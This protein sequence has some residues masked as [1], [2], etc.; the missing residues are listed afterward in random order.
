MQP[1]QINAGL[2]FL[3]GL[4]S[5]VSPCVLPLVPAY[6]S[7]LTGSTVEDLRENAAPDARRAAVAHAL[8]FILGFT[9]VFV[10][11]GATAT[12]AGAALRENQVLIA[13]IGGVIV[14]VLGLQMVGILR[15]RFLAM[16]TRVQVQ[17]KRRSFWASGLVG[18]AFAAGWSPCIGPILAAILT[19][20]A[21]E[22]SVG[23]GAWLLFVYSMGLAL[24]F[25][26]TAGALGLVLPL[27]ARIKHFMPVIEKTA[28]TFMILTGVVLVFNWFLKVAGFFYQYVPQPKL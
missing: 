17:T 28:G 4:V 1:A 20:A 16:D 11:L 18:L 9:I 5:F 23:Q 13:R 15:L 12:A 8:A 2:A 19:L 25:L 14:I 26:V 27:L 7:F 3:A 6:L 22:H 10:L 24:P 21:Q